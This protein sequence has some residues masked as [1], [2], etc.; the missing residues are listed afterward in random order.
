MASSRSSR[1][2]GV[3]VHTAMGANLPE[4]LLT[5]EFALIHAFQSDRM[6]WLTKR[7]DPP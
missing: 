2:S 6:A 5:A 3:A 1:E 4:V 7:R